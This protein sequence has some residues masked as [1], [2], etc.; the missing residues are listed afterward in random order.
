MSTWTR[1]DRFVS[2]QRKERTRPV[3]VLGSGLL[4]QCGL[5]KTADWTRMLRR[6]ANELRVPFDKHAAEEFPTLYWDT[7]IHRARVAHPK[8]FSSNKAVESSARR[9]VKAFV[10]RPPQRPTRPNLGSDL[11]K[12]DVLALIS[13]NFTLA[14]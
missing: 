7:L 1:L 5:G 11:L 13:L 9:A 6:V 2:E 14:P 8:Q 3:L 10:D 4:H 12:A